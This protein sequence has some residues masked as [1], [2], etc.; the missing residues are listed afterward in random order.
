M[1]KLAYTA[2]TA[3]GVQLE[4]DF[5]L[6]PLTASETDVATLLTNVLAALDTTIRASGNVSDGDVL[7]AL[8]MALAIRTR[9]VDTASGPVHRLAAELV[10]TAL[11][12]PDCGRPSRH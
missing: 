2:S 4:F 8:S 6:H 11:A 5:P 7:Q 3:S 10:D 9:M 12:A 1:N